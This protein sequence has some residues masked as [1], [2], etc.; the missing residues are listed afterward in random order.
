MES[1]KFSLMV[2]SNTELLAM[3]HLMRHAKRYWSFLGEIGPTTFKRTP[4]THRNGVTIGWRGQASYH[5]ITRRRDNRSWKKTC[6]WMWKWIFILSFVE[7]EKW[8]WECWKTPPSTI[9][10]EDWMQGHEPVKTWEAIVISSEDEMV[11][12]KQI[13]PEKASATSSRKAN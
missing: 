2:L 8:K 6:L 11:L 4:F 3:N 1:H 10:T 13:N 12:S 9:R 5:E 7:T